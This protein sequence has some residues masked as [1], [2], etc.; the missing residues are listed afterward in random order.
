M[1]VYFIGEERHYD[2]DCEP[3]H[4]WVLYRLL[5]YHRTI[6]GFRPVR[7]AEISVRRGSLETGESAA[8]IDPQR[9]FGSL[10]GDLYEEPT[11]RAP[12]SYGSYE[13]P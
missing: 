12:D 9:T 6:H 13:H 4:L 5:T 2:M 8:M 7:Y 3:E 10:I 1:K 11:D